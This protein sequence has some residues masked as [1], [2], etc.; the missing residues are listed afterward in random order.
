MRLAE[1]LLFSV[2]GLSQIPICLA[3]GAAGHEIVATI[4][5]IYLHPSTL[6]NVCDIL[7]P[8]SSASALS[9]PCYISKIAAWADQVK[10][11]PEY[12]YT[13]PLHYIGARDDHPSETCAFP[14]ARGWAGKPNMNVLGAIRNETSILIDYTDGLYDNAAAEDAIKFLV[15]Y[16]GDMHQ[17]LHLTGRDRG[18][19]GDKVLFDD[20]VTS[21]FLKS[22]LPE[23]R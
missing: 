9:P 6:N 13:A 20:R 21:E 10:R 5:Q 17:P 23:H 8:G 15:H 2:L 12:R 16:V 7:Y 22:N 3:W 4:A 11:R 18:G 14:G 1:I 19:N